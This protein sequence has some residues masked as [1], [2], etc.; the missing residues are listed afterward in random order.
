MSYNAVVNKT[1]ITHEAEGSLCSAPSVPSLVSLLPTLDS[2][3]SLAH[4]IV[5]CPAST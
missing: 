4:L 2:H 1:A 5:H 3:G